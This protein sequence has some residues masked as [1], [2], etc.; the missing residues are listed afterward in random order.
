MYVSTVWRTLGA[1]LA[2]DIAAVCLAVGFVGLSFGAI[3]TASGVPEWAV[4]A[5][6]L[7]VFAG[8][9]QFL[10]V[11]LLA[12]GN[13][14]AAI[15]GGLLLNARHLPFGLALSDVLAGGWGR[16]LIGSHLMVDEAVAFAL[17]QPSPERRR[18]AYWVTGATIF[19][20]WQIGTVGGIAVGSAVGDP[21]R[22]GL[23]AAFPAALLALLLPRLRERA[24]LRVGLIAAAVAVR[25]RSSSRRACRCCSVSSVCSRPAE[26]SRRWTR[27]K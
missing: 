16:R 14:I 21:A 17:A 10:A 23:D 20:C 24:G 22:Y 15:L 13:P 4:V 18:A 11:G 27:R 6:S 1:R 5:L 3:A 26:P 7:C 9:S 12:A 19:I 2:R 25:R 8:G